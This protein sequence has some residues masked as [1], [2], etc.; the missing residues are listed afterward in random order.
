MHAFFY[1]PLRLPRTYSAWIARIAAV[2]PRLVHALRQVRFGNFIYGKDTGIAP[3]LGSMARDLGLPEELGDPAKTIPV[4][5]VLVHHGLAKGC[6]EHGLRRFARAMGAAAGVYGPL[7]AFLLVRRFTGAKAPRDARARIVLVRRAVVDTLRSASFLASF[8]A[9]FY[10][11]V[12]LARTR[13]GPK[14]FPRVTPQMWD[15]GLC[16]LAGCMA[17]G[18][19]ILV[20]EP[21]RQVELMLFV[22]P[23]AVA[24][25]LPRRYEA[26]VSFSHL[27]IHKRANLTFTAS[28]ERAYYV[29]S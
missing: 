1:A 14:M 6:E 5:C 23:R 4:P 12:C 9:L 25:F 11:G 20:E 18:W 26:V 28:M 22:V 27:T 17:C 2:D 21:R 13:V 15:S 7:Q 16:I 3:L 10:Y 19:S 24:V 8:V 29:C